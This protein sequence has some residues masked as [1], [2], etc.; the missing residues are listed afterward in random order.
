MIH[1]LVSIAVR[2]MIVGELNYD[3]AQRANRSR[4]AAE[5]ESRIG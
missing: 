4:R 5:L 3:V 1:Y 2:G